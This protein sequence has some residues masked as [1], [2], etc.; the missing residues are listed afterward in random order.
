[1][2]TVSAPSGTGLPGTIDEIGYII[3]ADQHTAII[4]AY[5]E[6]PGT[7][8]RAGQYVSVTVKIP[9]PDDV[10]EIPAD[11]VID[12]GKQ[13]FVLVQPNP[14]GHHVTTRRVE[15]KR[16]LDG[17]VHVRS[18]PIPKKEQLTAAEAEQGLLPKEPLRAGEHV[19]VRGAP[20]SVDNRLNTLE[21]KL[22]QV[23]EAL[24]ALSPHAARKSELRE[25]DAPR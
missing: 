24:K 17:K 22:D 12:D 18:S 23:L 25:T 4:K 2:Q 6:N 10:V 9:P 3:N 1:M 20:E 11:A 19:L 14:A 8:I 21:R 15:V 7:H 16:R 13:T 5:V